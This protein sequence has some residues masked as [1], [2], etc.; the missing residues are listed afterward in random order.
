[1]ITCGSLILMQQPCIDNIS[2][3]WGTISDSNKTVSFEVTGKITK[4]KYLLP[5]VIVFFF[6]DRQN[7]EDN[8]KSRKYCICYSSGD[9]Q[10]AKLTLKFGLKIQLENVPYAEIRA[11]FQQ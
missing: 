11:S 1:M 10:H 9:T 6:C 8:K 3:F 7:L 2:N 4:K 5:I